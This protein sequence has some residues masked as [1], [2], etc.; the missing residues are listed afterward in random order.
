MTSSAT[1]LCMS[2]NVSFVHENCK[3]SSNS[4]PLSQ[5]WRELWSLIV[6][7]TPPWTQPNIWT[8]SPA[9]TCFRKNTDGLL[10]FLL[11]YSLL[12]TRFG[13][14]YAVENN[15]GKCTGEKKVTCFDMRFTKSQKQKREMNFYFWMHFVKS[16]EMIY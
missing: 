8:H 15:W 13:L 11:F 3:A 7:S 10:I 14:R 9:N 6:S 4:Q 1:T 12:L 5:T 2:C 16:P